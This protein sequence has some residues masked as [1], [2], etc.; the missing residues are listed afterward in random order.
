MFKSS[1]RQ[2]YRLIAKLLAGFHL[3]MSA[4]AIALP[5]LSAYLAGS[6]TRAEAQPIVPQPSMPPLPTNPPGTGERRSYCQPRQLL[7]SPAIAD[8][9]SPAA[10]I[11]PALNLQTPPPIAA[12]PVATAPPSPVPAAIETPP[13]IAVTQF[14]PQPYRLA[15][16]DQIFV[17]VQPYQNV[18]VQAVINPQG[19]IVMQLLGPVEVAGL[20]VEQAQQKIQTGL[21]QFLVNPI[22]SVA[23]SA[24][25]P[26]NVTITG[27]VTQPGFYTFPAQN[28][29]VS[30]ILAAVGGTTPSADL[31]SVLVRRP[32]GDGTFL[33]QRI[34]LLTP[35]QAGS[36]PPEVLLEEGDILVVP[37]QNLT[38]A[39]QYGT[40]VLGR[41]PLAPP[42]AVAI[43]VLGEV[44]RP[45][46]YNLPPSVNPV[47]DALTLAGGTTPAA[48][49]QSVRVQRI[50]SNGTVSEEVL[51]LYSP[52]ATGVPFPELRLGNGDV[53]IVP[54][55][56]LN[57]ARDYNS[58][59]VSNSTLSVPQPVGVTIV[60]EVTQPGFYAIPASPRPIPTALQTAGGTTPVADLRSVRVR[61]TLSNGTVSEEVVDLVTP[62]ATGTS[63][64]DL[65]LANGDVVIV[66]K[67]GLEEARTYNS[68]VVS[69][70]TLAAQQ[71]VAVTILG[72]VAAPGFHAIPPSPSPVPTALQVAG[73][74]TP[75]ADLRQ[76]RVC[77][78]LANGTVSEEV[79][80]LYD[81]LASG[82]TAPDL[83]LG[84]GDVV[85]VPKLAL[86]E[87]GEYNSEIVANST[88]AA[89][90]P[91]NVT[92]LGEVAQP[93]FFTLP[94]SQRPVADSLLLAGG[95]TSDADLRQVRVRRVQDNGAIA[96]EILDLYTPLLTG[97]ELPELRLANGDVVFIPQIETS[98]DEYYDRFL[99]SRSSLAVA[100]ITVRILS[101]PGGGINVVPIRNGS[102]F[103]DIVN[104]IPLATADLD[105][106]ALVRFDPEQGKAVTREIDAKQLL[107]G[108]T[109]QN[110]PL[111]NNDV[112][113][114]GRN[115]VSKITYALSTFT[116]PFRDILGFLLFFDSLRNSASLLF[117]P[118]SDN[119][120]NNGNNN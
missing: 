20:T 110:V 33:Q 113:I 60:G 64:P 45:G 74:I 25:R 23:L 66:P 16:Q 9:R 3:G 92:V 41:S 48:N 61:R 84:T 43:R 34:D 89:A 62:L 5:I 19:Q 11:P 29:R 97:S 21:N 51:D 85:I 24:K 10:P 46:F 120:N 86:N 68:T 7:P 49:L 111:Q 73:G 77:R 101:Y 93:G 63:F 98:T 56:T 57:Q 75:G 76:V 87:G 114:I 15:S 35:L 39:Q 115:L 109:S 71:A 22:V 103:A 47:Q 108:D 8:T 42:Q 58:S 52:L 72:E 106:I 95:I 18:S 104:A 70:S 105:S 116:Q 50:L 65:R 2:Y 119:N 27:E 31:T 80:N 40:N 88:L 38:Q 69:T 118:G 79:V 82:T 36:L 94:P 37:K 1:D 96:E 55:L 13:I 4:G 54:T 53:V 100:Q 17:D 30:E 102:T 32:V 112:I 67:L 90:I 12:P 6:A 91:V 83:R 59:L 117:G 14:Q 107:L 78:V 99:V 28:A 81:S 44:T 26:V